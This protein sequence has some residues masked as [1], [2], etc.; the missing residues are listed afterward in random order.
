MHKVIQ[1]PMMLSML[2]DGIDP[3]RCVGKWVRCAVQ[4]CE[5]IRRAAVCLDATTSRSETATMRRADCD[6]LMLL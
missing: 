4:V 5:F 3:C 2:H 1:L 6:D